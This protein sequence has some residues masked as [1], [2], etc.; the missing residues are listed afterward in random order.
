MPAWAV[1][2]ISLKN[3]NNYP[4][5]LTSLKNGKGTAAFV[6]YTP[7]GHEVFF[8]LV[9]LF[10]QAAVFMSKRAALRLIIISQPSNY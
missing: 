1:R 10:Q 3:L 7:L 8:F 5:N 4:L 9:I 2:S 6:F